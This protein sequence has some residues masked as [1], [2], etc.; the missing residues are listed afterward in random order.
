MKERMESLAKFLI[1]EAQK[2][3]KQA[4]EEGD[5]CMRG[6]EVAFELCAKWIRE[7]L[8]KGD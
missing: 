8:E 2:A 7:E 3:N 5:Y 4:K 1:Q 6:M